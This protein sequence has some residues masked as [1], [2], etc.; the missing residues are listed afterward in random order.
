VPLLISNLLRTYSCASGDASSEL[1]NELLDRSEEVSHLTMTVRISRH[2]IDPSQK[3]SQLICG[4]CRGMQTPDTKLPEMPQ[5][6][7]RCQQ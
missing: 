6:A 4:V 7:R 2:A 5:I 3:T 1:T